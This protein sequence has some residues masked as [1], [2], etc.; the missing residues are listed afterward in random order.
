[1]FLPVAIN[2]SC[3]HT[4]RL[5]CTQK[6]WT[7]VTQRVH[8][9]RSHAATLLHELS[10]INCSILFFHCF[11]RSTLTPGRL[12]QNCS[13]RNFVVPRSSRSSL[14]CDPLSRSSSHTAPHRTPSHTARTSDGRSHTDG[15]A[16]IP[17]GH[18]PWHLPDSYRFSTTLTEVNQSLQTVLDG[19]HLALTLTG[20]SDAE[21]IGTPNFWSLF[22]VSLRGLFWALFSGL[23][24]SHF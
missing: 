15:T 1:M 8:A 19:R 7:H 23:L 18:A 3:T 12:Q 16:C 22:L 17:P 5:G 20:T 11:N 10:D 14:R 6:V 13:L 4:H 9:A 2:T 21:R 24:K